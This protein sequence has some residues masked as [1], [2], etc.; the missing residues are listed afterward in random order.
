ME[1]A[2]GG[3]EVDNMC[4]WSGI[5]IIWL[6]GRNVQGT[7][8]PSLGESVRGSASQRDQSS[9][10]GSGGKSKSAV[11]SC[12]Q[13]TRTT[14]EERKG[15]ND[16][17][18]QSPGGAVLR[19]VVSDPE[20]RSILLEKKCKTAQVGDYPSIE[21]GKGWGRARGKKGGWGISQYH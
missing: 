11:F 5:G 18:V 12:R 9:E 13:G 14:K 21:R 3:G 19:G 1:T 2:E 6:G 16:L 17:A 20:K 4:F 7:A 8:C 10:E 15:Q